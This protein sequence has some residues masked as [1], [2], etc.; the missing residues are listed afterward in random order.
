MLSVYLRKKGIFTISEWAPKKH[1]RKHLTTFRLP[2]GSISCLLSTEACQI[3]IKQ[4]QD[5]DVYIENQVLTDT[6]ANEISAQDLNFTTVGLSGNQSKFRVLPCGPVPHLGFAPR[7]SH[8][9]HSYPKSSKISWKFPSPQKQAI[10]NFPV[11]VNAMNARLW[12]FVH[13]TSFFS[14]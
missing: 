14:S 12:R 7:I 1:N 3:T 4:E 2:C 5:K 6:K 13:L 8:L 9:K 10:L 11:A